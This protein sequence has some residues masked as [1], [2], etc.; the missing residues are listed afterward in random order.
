MS[1]LSVEKMLSPMTAEAA[2]IIRRNGSVSD[3]KSGGYIGGF[4]C[5]MADVFRLIRQEPE[6][7]LFALLQWGCITLAYMG[8]VQALD[9]IPD[10]VWEE[11]RSANKDDRDSGFAL[12]NLFLIGWSFVIV[13]CVSFPLSIL[14]AGM[15]A[16]H[17]LRHE[18][19]ESTFFYAVWRGMQNVGQQWVFTTIDAWITV[20]AIFDRL[21][22]K[23]NRDRRTLADEALYYAWKLG[24][25]G[26]VPAM[27][28]GRG[29]IGAAKD[30]LTMVK[31]EPGLAIAIRFGY[32]GVCWIIGIA[33]YVAAV[34]FAGAKGLYAPADNGIYTF[35]FYMTVPIFVSVGIISVFVR[36]F[37]LL[38]VAKLY[39]DVLEPKGMLDVAMSDEAEQVET[40]PAWPVFFLAGAVFFAVVTAVFLA[41]DIGLRGWVEDLAAQDFARIAE[42]RDK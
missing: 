33:T 22:K 7:L 25:M 1:F 42:T 6:I 14:S 27:V 39:T 35:Y 28:Y 20:K 17:A 34:L 37:F 29:L 32:S 41:D 31:R 9:W 2:E 11:I 5:N 4:F 15:V 8:W 12:L 13:V 26:M 30:S 24:T 36:P 3:I 16:V 18:G 40:A 23:R 10:S 19:Y 38:M 21:P